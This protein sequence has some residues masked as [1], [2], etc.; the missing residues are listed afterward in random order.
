[1]STID[2]YLMKN[3]YNPEGG[4][5]TFDSGYRERLA[6]QQ[7]QKYG[8]AGVEGFRAA[9]GLRDTN[10]LSADSIRHVNNLFT[11][12]YSSVDKGTLAS[13]ASG[14]LK[15]VRDIVTPMIN[16]ATI[17]MGLA[18]GVGLLGQLGAAAGGGM[19]GAGAIGATGGG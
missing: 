6:N 17:A 14:G 10:G 12:K 5:E 19:T 8:N 1:M 13:K 7:G 11:G 3:Y 2:N 9:Y 16:P 18:G 15:K 4:L